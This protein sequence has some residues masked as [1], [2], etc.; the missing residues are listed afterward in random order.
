MYSCGYMYTAR[1]SSMFLL[2]VVFSCPEY[3]YQNKVDISPVRY[4]HILNHPT[5]DCTQ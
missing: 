2:A 5:E 3:L 1:S 4:Y